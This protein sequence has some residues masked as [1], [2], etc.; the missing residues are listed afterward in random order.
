MLRCDIVWPLYPKQHCDHI[1]LI[2]NQTHHF[3]MA[4]RSSKMQYGIR[5]L[6][7]VM[8]FGSLTTF[9]HPVQGGT[10]DG[11]ESH[12]LGICKSCRDKALPLCSFIM[13]LSL[14]PYSSVPR[15][16]DPYFPL[17]HSPKDILLKL[18]KCAPRTITWIAVIHILSSL[19]QL[20]R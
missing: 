7:P 14:L 17:R 3:P 10:R 18:S 8:L 13:S 19:G 4:F 11:T 2:P 1:S 9:Y 12:P 20:I 16:S 6:E 15:S 5:K